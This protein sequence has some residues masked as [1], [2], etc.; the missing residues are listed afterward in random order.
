MPLFAPSDAARNQYGVGWDL[1]PTRSLGVANEKV[2]D[3][4]R[5]KTGRASPL[6]G[7]IQVNSV[8][9]FP[10]PS[11]KF[12]PQRETEGDTNHRGTK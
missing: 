5:M 2:G 7:R 11:D 6:V 8:G 1:Y 10:V 9:E 12:L 4:H 3:A